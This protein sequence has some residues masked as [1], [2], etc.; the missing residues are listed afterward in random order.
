[1][2]SKEKDM[3]F[4]MKEDKLLH[5]SQYKEKGWITQ[6]PPE[7]LFHGLLWCYAPLLLIP[8]FLPLGLD[9]KDQHIK[10]RLLCIIQ[11]IHWKDTPDTASE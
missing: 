3:Q 4:S 10:A 11:D 7:F 2:L 5:R 6:Q 9:A 8:K 1:M